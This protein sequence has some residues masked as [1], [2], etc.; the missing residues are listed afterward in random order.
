MKKLIKFE[1]PHCKSK[2][3][4]RIDESMVSYISSWGNS[5]GAF[6]KAFEFMDKAF[7]KME[8]AFDRLMK[9]NL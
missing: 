3:T 2:F 1:C 5:W 9:R 6:D 7:E 4:V 8:E